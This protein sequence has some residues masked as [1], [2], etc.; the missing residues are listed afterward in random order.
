MEFLIFLYAML[1]LTGLAV[2]FV[3]H[4]PVNREDVT[5]DI[6][7]YPELI[8]S[9]NKQH[10]NVAGRIIAVIFYTLLFAPAI[11]VW[12][13]SIGIFLLMCQAGIIFKHVFRERRK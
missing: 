4:A 3:N 12:Y 1:N 6:F 9:L 10:I 13:V 11:A 2:Q 8:A 7:I 5:N